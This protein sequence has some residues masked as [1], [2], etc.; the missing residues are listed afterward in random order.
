MKQLRAQQGW[1]CRRLIATNYEL[2]CNGREKNLPSLSVERL[3][4]E[5]SAFDS[6]GCP[7]MA[8]T[9]ASAMSSSRYWACGYA[10]LAAAAGM[11]PGVAALAPGRHHHHA[12]L[13]LPVLGVRCG[14]LGGGG[15]CAARRPGH[16]ARPPPLACLFSVAGP[17]FAVW[18]ALRRRLLVCRSPPRRLVPCRHQ[19]C[20]QLWCRPSV[21]CCELGGDGGWCAAPR[22]CLWSPSSPRAPPVY[23]RLGVRCVAVCDACRTCAANLRCP[24]SILWH[25][26]YPRATV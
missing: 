20:C 16:C 15:R 12:L 11:P 8:S 14:G 26:P 2:E 17:G 9:S 13:P 7:H 22:W 18:R 1:Y 19:G 21:G 5:I 4:N 10:F 3:F 23:V 24:W 25:S 6:T